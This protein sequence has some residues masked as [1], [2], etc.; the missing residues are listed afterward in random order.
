MFQKICWL[1]NKVKRDL[2]LCNGL[3]L[4]KLEL[5]SPKQFAPHLADPT[6]TAKVHVHSIALLMGL[7]EATLC[8]ASCLILLN[9]QTIVVYRGLH[10]LKQK[11]FQGTF[12]SEPNICTKHSNNLKNTALNGSRCKQKRSSAQP[13]ALNPCAAC[14]DIKNNMEP[15]NPRRYMHVPGARPSIAPAASMMPC[16]TSLPH[17]HP[18]DLTNFCLAAAAQDKQ[19]S[20][21]TLAPSSV[22]QAWLGE[23]QSS[24]TTV[25]C[26]CPAG[27]RASPS[28][29]MNACLCTATEPL[30]GFPLCALAHE[31][32]W[33]R[34]ESG[35]RT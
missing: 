15:S 31:V 16:G 7:Q 10:T 14:A 25:L 33:S 17:T 5:K 23:S 22:S 35:Q 27:C 1:H 13:S 21:W 32:C 19:W 34:T 28:A 2:T 18:T 20:G 26:A 24:S 9:N 8:S 11:W 4:H 30:L 12:E 6:C 29:P 3:S